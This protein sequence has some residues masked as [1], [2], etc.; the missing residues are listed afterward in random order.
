[1]I[2]VLLLTMSGAITSLCLMIIDLKNHGGL[3]SHHYLWL[4]LTIFWFSM[5]FALQVLM[6]TLLLKAYTV[7]KAASRTLGMQTQ[8]QTNQL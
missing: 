1:M 6:L 4:G 7:I 8:Q 5:I 2:V 3:G